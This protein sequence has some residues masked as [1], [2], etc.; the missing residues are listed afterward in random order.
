[1]GFDFGKFEEG[2]LSEAFVEWLV[3]EQWVAGGAHFGRLW[4]YYDNPM[5]QV[6][7]G[8]NGGDS[9]SESGRNYVQ[10][11]EVGLP[12]RITG[13]V[14]S[15]SNGADAGRSVGDI[16]RKEVVIENDIAWRINAMVDFLFGD[17]LISCIPLPKRKSTIALIRQAISFSMTTSL[18]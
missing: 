4:D 7:Q 1:M 18:R 10:A 13:V 17:L 8:R 14:Y 12:A 5:R 3:E 15:H 11:Q 2:G 16:Q 6:V 9:V